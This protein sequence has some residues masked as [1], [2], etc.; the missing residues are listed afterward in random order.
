MP[1]RGER[2]KKTFEKDCVARGQHTAY[3]DKTIW[4]KSYKATLFPYLHYP[5]LPL[6]LKLFK[7]VFQ[8]LLLL[9]LEYEVLSSFQP[10]FEGLF[11]GNLLPNAADINCYFWPFS[12]CGFPPPQ[13]SCLEN[14]SN[15]K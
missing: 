6:P 9:V 1:G 2:R 10:P 4:P 8:F 15:N 14:H 3:L 7:T 11:R 12:D 5:L 13:F